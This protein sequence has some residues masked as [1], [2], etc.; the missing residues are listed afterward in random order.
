MSAASGIDGEAERLGQ[1]D[2]GLDVGGG[3]VESG[4]EIAQRF[5]RL[6]LNAMELARHLR[7]GKGPAMGHADNALGRISSVSPLAIRSSVWVAS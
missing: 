5:M 3:D 2:G 6:G 7:D 1:R 4:G